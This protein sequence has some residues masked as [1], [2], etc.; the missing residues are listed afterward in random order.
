MTIGET[1]FRSSGN[2]AQRLRA[3][4]PSLEVLLIEFKNEE[5]REAGGQGEFVADFNIFSY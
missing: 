4:A 1:S 5:K 2:S 3:R